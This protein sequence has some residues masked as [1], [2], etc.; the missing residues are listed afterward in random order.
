MSKGNTPNFAPKVETADAE[1]T[2]EVKEVEEIPLE[3]TAPEE[4]ENTSS[5]AAD[6]YRE[7]APGV[8]ARSTI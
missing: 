4:V 7:V 1:V 3:E 2:D 8:R 6:G 5:P